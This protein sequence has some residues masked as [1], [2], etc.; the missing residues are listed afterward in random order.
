MIS[1]LIYFICFDILKLFTFLI[2][3][4][5]DFI[6]K[7]KSPVDIISET[8]LSVSNSKVSSQ[9]SPDRTSLSFRTHAWD[10]LCWSAGRQ[11]SQNWIRRVVLRFGIVFYR[12]MEWLLRLS[13][14]ISNQTP[15]PHFCSSQTGATSEAN[16]TTQTGVAT[17]HNKSVRLPTPNLTKKIN[18]NWWGK[19]PQ[20]GVTNKSVRQTHKLVRLEKLQ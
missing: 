17:Y 20:T 1:T 11:Q 8:N 5:S 9:N 12:G 13:T 19:H 4:L 3:C 6:D 18:T 14:T 16:Q 15:T 7:C 2:F 10:D